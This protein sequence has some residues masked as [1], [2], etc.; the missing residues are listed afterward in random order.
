MSP[1]TAE[2]PP[3]LE[4]KSPFE[5]RVH[6]GEGMPETDVRSAV[7]LLGE[8]RA[9]SGDR[10]SSFEL[11]SRVGLELATRHI[12]GVSDPLGAAHPW[13]VLCELSSSRAAEPLDAVL[14]E[15]LGAALTRGT[16][17]DAALTRSEREMDMLRQRPLVVDQ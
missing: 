5:M 9:A 6:L 12:P 14:E 11:I 1:Q 7:A 8:L 10:I 13:Y 15:E 4:A 3:P 17:L 2:K 16:V